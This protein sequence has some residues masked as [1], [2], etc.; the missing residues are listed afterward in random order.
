MPEKIPTLREFSWLSAIPH[1]V[2][3]V[4]L[5][6][7]SLAVF[8]ERSTGLAAGAGA[9]LVLSRGL[10]AALARDHARGIRLLHEGRFEEAIAAFETSHAFFSAHPRLDRWRYLTLLSSSAYSYRELALCNIAFAHLQ[11]GRVE[12]ALSA[13]RQ[14]VAAF[15]GCA[16]ARH[17]IQALEAARRE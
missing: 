11:S 17:S 14:A 5:V 2:V 4:V 10:K 6:G 12:P 16:L 3:M 15:P 8:E 1:L 7:T 9:Y 13:Y